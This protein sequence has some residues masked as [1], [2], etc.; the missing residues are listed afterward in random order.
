MA[1]DQVMT[2]FPSVVQM[3]QSRVY[4]FANEMRASICDLLTPENIVT[5]KGEVITPPPTHTHTFLVFMSLF[6]SF[7]CKWTWAGASLI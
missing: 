7:V 3:I 4:D 1:M 2:Y 5:L 6:L